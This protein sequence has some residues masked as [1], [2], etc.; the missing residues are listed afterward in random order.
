MLWFQKKMWR[1][2]FFCRKVRNLCFETSESFKFDQ[3]SYPGN[4]L[5]V[6][7]AESSYQP[8]RYS[9][10]SARRFDWVYDQ[11]IESWVFEEVKAKLGRWWQCSIN[12]V[13]KKSVPRN[14]GL[15]TILPSIIVYL[16]CTIV[17]GGSYTQIR[18]CV[19]SEES[20]RWKNVRTIHKT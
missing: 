18:P 10:F 9:L 7:I 14:D 5:S 1:T 17:S 8:I 11:S 6:R 19:Y 3:W 16:C 12:F 4:I 15:E 20:E 2:V 13:S